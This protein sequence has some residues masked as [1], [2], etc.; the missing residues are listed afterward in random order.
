ME[1]L[2][3][4]VESK[5][6]R[7]SQ[8]EQ[9]EFVWVDLTNQKVDDQDLDL[10]GNGCVRLDRQRKSDDNHHQNDDQA[11][12]DLGANGRAKTDGCDS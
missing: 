12:D 6:G 3:S 11:E 8:N 10:A 2:I 1:D 5:G 9:G 7:I 4:F